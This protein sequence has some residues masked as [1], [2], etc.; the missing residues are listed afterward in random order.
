MHLG[1]NSSFPRLYQC[2][3]SRVCVLRVGGGVPLPQ[4]TSLPKS[5]QN[6]SGLHPE[7]LSAELRQERVGKHAG[8]V[9]SHWTGGPQR[10]V[11]GGGL[12]AQTRGASVVCG[13]SF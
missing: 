11:P 7:G 8:G 12:V 10:L 5:K 4:V 9:L 3:Q 1:G 13:G 2:L 6:R